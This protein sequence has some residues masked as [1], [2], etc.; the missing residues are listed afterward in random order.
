M[1]ILFISAFYPPHVVGG[2]EQLVEDINVRLQARGHTTRVLT[3]TYGIGTPSV[4]GNVDRLLTLESELYHYNPYQFYSHKYR[5]NRNL[6]QVKKVIRS[7]TPDVVFVHVMWNLSR[8]IAWCAEQLCPGRVVYYVANDWPHAPDPHTTYWL[9]PARNPVRRLVK[10]W[11]APLLLKIIQSE[12]EAFPLQF[13]HVL[14]VSRAVREDLIYKANIPAERIQVVYNGVETDLFVPPAQEVGDGRKGLSLLYAGSL[15]PHKGVHTAIEAMA[16]LAQKPDM[17]DVTLTLVGSGHPDYEARLRKRVKA[18]CIGDNVRF[19]GRIPRAEM[20]ALLQ[21]FDV[22]VFPSVWEE[23]LARMIQEAMAAGL[24]VIGTLTGG[25]GELLIEGETGLTFA[26]E[27]ADALA[28]R[29]EQLRNNPTLRARL[30]QKARGIV[31]QSFDIRRMVDE[32][33]SVLHRAVGAEYV[34]MHIRVSENA[35]VPIS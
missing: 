31:V 34:P 18:S 17:A 16:I 33:E 13:Q 26:P 35:D 6:D 32:I 3:S 8:G 23:P 28:C 27:D 2:W 25:T 10:Q 19:L 7:F 4:E 1:R 20:P 22:L 9:S 24:V 15:V 12:N 11:V 5:L 21:Q 14:C 29:I 30:A